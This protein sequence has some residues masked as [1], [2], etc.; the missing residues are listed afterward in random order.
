LYDYDR[1]KGEQLNV[2]IIDGES[3]NNIDSTAIHAFK[4]IVLD[5]NSREIEVY[6]TGIKG[7]VRDKFNSSGFIK[8]A[9]EGHFFLSIQEAI[10]FYEAKQKNKA[11][12]KIYKK[13]VEQVNK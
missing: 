13:Y 1:Q 11:N 6:F 9:K 4:E 10:D 2:L 12:T 8:V 3:I 5:F 7:P